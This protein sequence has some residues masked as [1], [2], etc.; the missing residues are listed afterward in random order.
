MDAANQ[1]CV[2]Y[3]LPKWENRLGKAQ[4][5]NLGK[6]H[7]FARFKARRINHNIPTCCKIVMLSQ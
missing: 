6:T 4:E 5:K 2:Q 7:C 1:Q 3:M